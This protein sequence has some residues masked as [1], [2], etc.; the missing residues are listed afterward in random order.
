M[1]WEEHRKTGGISEKTFR[2]LYGHITTKY[3]YK[4]IKKKIRTASDG[5]GKDFSVKNPVFSRM[6]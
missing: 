5:H 1:N 3:N 4:T 6:R 2:K